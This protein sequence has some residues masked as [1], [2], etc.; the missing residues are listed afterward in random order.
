MRNRGQKSLGHAK[1]NTNEGSVVFE[2]EK[3][4]GEPRPSSQISPYFFMVRPE[5]FEPPTPGFEGREIVFPF[6]FYYSPLK[7]KKQRKQLVAKQAIR[8]CLRSFAM[9]FGARGWK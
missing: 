6:F 5:G 3:K 9:L 4:K 7:Y 8:F 1:D 2:A